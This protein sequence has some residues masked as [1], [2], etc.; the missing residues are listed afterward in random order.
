[1]LRKNTIIAL[2]PFIVIT[3]VDCLAKEPLPDTRAGSTST[4][5]ASLLWEQGQKAFQ[6]ESY[7][8]AV[9]QLKRLIDRYPGVKGFTEAHYLLGSSF[10]ELKRPKEALHPLRYYVSANGKTEA[11]LNG[12]VKLAEAYLMLKKFNEAYLT[13][14]EIVSARAT[15]KDNVASK[16]RSLGWPQ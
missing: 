2:L 15:K 14:G 10:I 1:M 8:E 3:S 5:E 7:Q 6:S 4:A 11:G 13:A 16:S 9:N 12:R